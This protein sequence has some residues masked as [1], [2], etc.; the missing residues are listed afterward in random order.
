M[1]VSEWNDEALKLAVTNAAEQGL[2]AAASV[3]IT[4]VKDKLSRRGASYKM[5]RTGRR[6]LRQVERDGYFKLST[7]GKNAGKAASNRKRAYEAAVEEKEFGKVD[8]PG[9]YP[10]LR[11]GNL[12]RA[13]DFERSGTL[14][15]LLGYL[16][17]GGANI[18][19]AVHEFGNRT[20]PARPVW[21][22]TWKSGDIQDAM[23]EAFAKQSKIDLEAGP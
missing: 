9:G 3:F 12:R 16:S 14:T 22:P 10:R 2:D 6:I 18:Y 11:T 19:G 20:T 1:P 7:R 5:L 4:S 17:T 23:F 21:N 8:P 15:R 13:A